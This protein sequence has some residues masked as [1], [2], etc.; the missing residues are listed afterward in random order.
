MLD[1]EQTKREKIKQF[2]AFVDVPDHHDT[3]AYLISKGWNLERARHAFLS[4]K[5]K[6][7]I[8]VEAFS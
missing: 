3:E 1:S 8:P 5:Q 4:A 6:N 2:R 7:E